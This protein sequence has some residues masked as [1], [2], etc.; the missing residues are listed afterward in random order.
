MKNRRPKWLRNGAKPGRADARPEDATP[1]PLGVREIPEG[2]D[3][4]VSLDLRC[5]RCGLA[6]THEVGTILMVPP[7][8]SDT[9]SR[10]DLESRLGFTGIARCAGCDATGPWGL[11]DASVKT[12]VAL[13]RNHMS[14]GKGNR[15]VLARLRMFDGTLV[16]NGADGVRHLQDR[17]LRDPGS[18]FLWDR[19]GNQY[20]SAEHPSEAICAW[21]RAL[22]L[23]PS[24]APSLFSLG[25]LLM[26]GGDRVGAV[27]AWHRFLR[28]VR[29]FERLD[30]GTKRKFTRTVLEGLLEAHEG[31]GGSL[32]GLPESAPAAPVEG[33]EAVLQLRSY[34]LSR[35][36]DWDRLVDEF[37][38]P[39][40]ESP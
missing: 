11:S 8:S 32:R 29:G 28:C 19:L 36:D 21:R 15:F 25:R 16:R 39:W 12:V 14:G 27:D 30:R 33:C 40:G 2:R 37:V 7:T 3:P 23:D 13:A 6:A 20:D 9:P 18:A 24:F 34:D 22:E 10:Q 5:K 38:R 26:D 35:P 4:P 31:S 17:I 1:R